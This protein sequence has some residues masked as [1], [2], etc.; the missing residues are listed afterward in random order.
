MKTTLIP[1]FSTMAGLL[2]SLTFLHLFA[3]HHTHHLSLASFRIPMS[4]RVRASRIAASTEPSTPIEILRHAGCASE[5]CEW[6]DFIA[7]RIFKQYPALATIS[8]VGRELPPALGHAV[9]VADGD[10]VGVGAGGA[11]PALEGI[12]DELF[13]AAGPG[14]GGIGVVLEG[15]VA[16]AADESAPDGHARAEAPLYELL[17]HLVVDL[18]DGGEEHAIGVDAVLDGRVAH[19]QLP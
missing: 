3:R 19:P 13:G 17:G 5:S 16:V 9:G 6:G 8:L 18:A 10:L 15:Q 2:R 7:N 12:G 11:D 4:F 14:E 1:L